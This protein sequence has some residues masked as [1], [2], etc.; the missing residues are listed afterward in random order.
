[1]CI[2]LF[3]YLIIWAILFVLLLFVC[4]IL[5]SYPSF[6]GKTSYDKDDVFFFGSVF[7]FLWPLTIIGLI[8]V[9]LGLIPLSLGKIVGKH[10]YMKRTKNNF[11]N[12]I[13]QK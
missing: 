6:L 8:F 4:G 1:M 2:E 11:K 12:I 5:K 9:G 3:V 13:S 7:V 10:M